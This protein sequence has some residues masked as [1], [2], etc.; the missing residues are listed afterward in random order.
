M[1]HPV[2]TGSDGPIGPEGRWQNRLEIR[3]LVKDRK[4]FSL[5]I[6]ALKA[7]MKLKSSNSLSFTSIA[8]IH[9]MPYVQWGQSGGSAKPPNVDFGGYCTHG[10]VLFPT[11]HRPYV[12]LF[13]QELYDHA[14]KIAETYTGSD[15]SEWQDAGRNLRSPYW[16]WASYDADKK[17]PE[18]LTLPTIRIL[19]KH[20]NELV[21]NPLYG[22]EFHTDDPIS[23]FDWPFNK[24]SRSLRHPK[25]GDSDPKNDMRSFQD[26]YTEACEQIRTQMYYCLVT[27]ET[28]DSL[29]NHTA[30]PDSRDIAGSLEAI[31]DD[32]HVLI[33]GTKPTGHMADSTVSAFDPIFFLHHANLDRMLALW[34]A[35][36]PDVWVS[37]GDQPHGTWTIP[38]NGTVDMTTDLAPFWNGPSSYWDSK[39]VRTTEALRYTYPEFNDIESNDPEEIKWLIFRKVNALYAPEDSV[40]AA[41][42]SKSLSGT[43]I[44]EWAVRIKFK[45]Q[46]LGASFSIL[47]YLG[48]TYVGRVSAFTAR[49]PRRCANCVRNANVEIEGYVHLTQA[50]RGK[51]Q[52]TIFLDLQSTLGCLKEDLSFR[53]R[54]TKKDGTAAKMNDLTSLKAMTISY[55]VA[56]GPFDGRPSYGAIEYHPSALVGKPGH[57][58]DPS[59]F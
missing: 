50:I 48:E 33:G 36:N 1:S 51:Y 35:L 56:C 9:G 2:V 46:E 21:E 4:Q 58:P 6:Q 38:K 42:S 14:N 17:L 15:A 5:Y 3:E 30:N 25:I 55:T 16:D 8:G 40:S 41:S 32:M 10:S 12:A 39:F 28:W 53:L 45:K 57:V 22:Y 27:L 24:W 7:M 47:V 34:S 52:S 37:Q 23:T 13:E 20:G 11:W 29:S 49:E 18:V 31:H 43:S 26:E 54:G 59:Q 19:T 44:H